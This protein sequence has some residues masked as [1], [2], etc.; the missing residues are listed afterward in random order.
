MI[1]RILIAL[2]LVF[3][4]WL[5]WLH[6]DWSRG[7]VGNLRQQPEP[8]HAASTY[9]APLRAISE[10]LLAALD[11]PAA[12]VTGDVERIMDQAK[13]DLADRRM[14]SGEE[15]S[16]QRLRR[17][18]LR[19]QAERNEYLEGLT[20]IR[21]RPLETLQRPANPERTRE[22]L[23]QEHLRSWETRAAMYRAQIHAELR[24]LNARAQ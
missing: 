11:V 6:S 5:L 20:H 22:F 13:A 9:G 12:D 17:M 19:L 10:Q 15:Q 1:S 14:S 18:I 8:V 16:V 2:M 3:L 24:E 4:G 21:T 7:V 23:V